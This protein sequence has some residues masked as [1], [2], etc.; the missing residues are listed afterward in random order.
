MET[1]YIV[2]IAAA[3]I[4]VLVVAWMYRDRLTEGWFKGSKEGVEAGMKAAPPPE[5]SIASPAAEEQAAGKEPQ[6]RP[7]PGVRLHGDFQRSTVSDLAGRDI[8]RGEGA[9]PR[10]GG[11]TP[12]VELD[13]RFPEAEVRDLAGRDRI[14]GQRLPEPEPP[15]GEEATDG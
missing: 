5:S 7:A 15:T 10:R 12:G 6:P 13:G 2:L 8:V 3:A 11:K 1:I 9:A 14:E 4:V